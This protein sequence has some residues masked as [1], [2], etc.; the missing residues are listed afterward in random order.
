MAFFK[1]LAAA[2]LFTSIGHGWSP[3]FLPGCKS[4]SLKTPLSRESSEEDQ[5]R[6]WWSPSVQQRLDDVRCGER[7]PL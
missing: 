3:N 5:L 2:F 7:Q 1:I 4:R 6:Y